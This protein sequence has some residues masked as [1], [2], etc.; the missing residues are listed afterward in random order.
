MPPHLEMSITPFSLHAAVPGWSCTGAVNSWVEWYCCV[1][2]TSF[3]LSLPRPL[4]LTVLPYLFCD[5]FSALLGRS[6]VSIFHLWLGIPLSLLWWLFLMF[7]CFIPPPFFLVAMKKYS[8][9]HLKKASLFCVIVWGHM[10]TGVVHHG[11]ESMGLGRW[12]NR[13]HCMH[14]QEAEE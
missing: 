2:K 8:G 9:K 13:P 11:V 5:V 4:A 1:Q 12:G 14:H 10:D 7:C 3:D 6:V